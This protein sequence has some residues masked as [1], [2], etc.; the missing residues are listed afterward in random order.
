ME[1]L[2]MKQAQILP[3]NIVGKLNGKRTITVDMVSNKQ[4]AFT[5]G[6]RNDSLFKLVCSLKRQ[7]VQQSTIRQ[8]ANKVNK[9]LCKPALTKK[10]VNAIINS[11]SKYDKDAEADFQSMSD[12]TT[13]GVDW[14]WY[15][16]LPRGCIIFLDGHPGKGKSYF[17]M[18]LAAM[19]SNGGELPFSDQRIA[20]GRV[21]I[22]NIED[23]PAKTMRP[24]LE[25][26]GANFDDDSIHFQS[27]FKPLTKEGLQT[28][29]SK[30]HDFKP[31]VVIID[32][33]LTYMGSN[34][35][36][37]RFNEVT[38]FL[39]HL[40]A[41]AREHNI[42]FICIR[43]MAKSGGEHSLNK[44]LGSIGFVARA[45]SVLHIGTSKDDPN[46]KGMAHVKS[47]WS[48]LG[49]T[50]LFELVGG[51]PTEHPKL[52]WVG[53]ADYGAEGL[54]PINGV[55]RPRAEPNISEVLIELL[56]NGPKKIVDIQDT[57][58]NRGMNISKSTIIRELRLIADLK[59][60]GSNSL[61]CLK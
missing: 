5:E 20:K 22:L 56:L 39:S 49:D 1:R 11:A 35:D 24:R 36:P 27:K 58:K 33:L 17:T 60:K 46:I 32:P 18:S 25:K 43:H 55:G 15:P 47:N 21:L 8:L 38:E 16:Y 3:D 51:S 4:T 29:E 41:I 7:S 48:E 54:D 6:N 61:W 23:D 42:C 50:L 28:L 40:D 53:V 52:E 59:G 34:T 37:N 45:R 30:I 12:I 10:E 2:I 13:E 14:Y 57:V 26:A 9:S 31:D 44:G 19:C